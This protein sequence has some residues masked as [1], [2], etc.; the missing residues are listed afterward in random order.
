MLDLD[1]IAAT[2]ANAHEG[3]NDG[4]TLAIPGWGESEWAALFRYT[5][6]STLP[7][8]ATLIQLND[9]DRTLYFLA[10]GMLEI[11]VPYDNLALAPLRR[12]GSGAVVGEIAFFDGGPRSARVWAVD[13]SNLLR[14]THA[15]Y[16]R[17]AATDQQRANELLFALAGVLAARLRDATRRGYRRGSSEVAPEIQTAR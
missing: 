7:A 11:V 14:L 6:A 17:F 1:A 16:V 4:S 12:L 2:F 15:D 5:T 10:S 3:S 13:D 8:G 9:H